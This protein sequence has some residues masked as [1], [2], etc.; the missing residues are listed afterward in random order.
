MWSENKSLPPLA[1]SLFLLFHSA[2]PWYND[3]M[4]SGEA[5]GMS[6]EDLLGTDYFF[7]AFDDLDDGGPGRGHLFPSPLSRSATS[8]RK[9]I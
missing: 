7:H 4:T 9:F 5:R 2:L 6:D 1:P 3:D 8:F